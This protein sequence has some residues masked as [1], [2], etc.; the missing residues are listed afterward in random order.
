MKNEI[1]KAVE[2]VLKRQKQHEQWADGYWELY[3]EYSAK[4]NNTE[5]ERMQVAYFLRKAKENEN[6]CQALDN[7]LKDMEAI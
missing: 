4:P 1:K 2:K 5:A 6:I 3:N 7:V